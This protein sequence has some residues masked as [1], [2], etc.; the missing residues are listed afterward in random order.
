MTTRLTTDGDNAGELFNE[1]DHS[2]KQ[3]IME[4]R[5]ALQQLLQSGEERVIDFNCIHCKHED[6]S[7]LKEFLGDGEVNATI[8]LCGTCCVWETSVHG[9]WWVVQK[10]DIGAIIAKALHIS[11]AP[12][13]LMAQ[14]EDV[15]YSLYMLERK[16]KSLEI[17]I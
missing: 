7:L 2:A 16:I 4:I 12:G 10:N 17:S 11:F 9:V 15:E 5:Q 1:S 14:H 6:E 8:R 3:I 13:I